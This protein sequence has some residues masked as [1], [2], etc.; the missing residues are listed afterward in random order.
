MGW[1]CLIGWL[2]LYLRWQGNKGVDYNDGTTAKVFSKSAIL[3]V[4]VGAIQSQ[5][6]LYNSPLAGNVNARVHAGQ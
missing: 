4:F 6:S 3:Y 5:I 2:V 1:F